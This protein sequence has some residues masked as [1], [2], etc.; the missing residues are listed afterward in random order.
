[1]SGRNPGVRRTDEQRLMT[2]RPIDQ[3][4][5]ATPGAVAHLRGKLRIAANHLIEQ[6][7]KVGRLEESLKGER[8]VAETLRWECDELIDAIKVLGGV[9]GDA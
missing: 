1:M 4:H 5:G 7:D 3:E 6:V 8:A 2:G 9:T